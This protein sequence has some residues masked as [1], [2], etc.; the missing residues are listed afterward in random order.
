MEIKKKPRARL[1]NYSHLFLLIGLVLT[2]FLT[3]VAFE[4]KSYPRKTS[5]FN[6]VQMS[7]DI[8]E[9]MVITHRKEPTVIPLPPPPTPQMTEIIKVVDDIEDIPE[10][11]IHS[12][13]TDEN[14]AVVVSER[15]QIIEE[16]EEEEEIIQDVPFAI[17]EDIP[18]FPGCENGSKDEKKACFSKKIRKHINKKFDTQLGNELGLTPGKKK[19]YVMFTI[20]ENGEITEVQS[21]APHPRL[22]SE[23][24]RVVKSLPKMTP[25]KQRGTPVRVKY[26]VPITFEVIL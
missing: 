19:I 13:E 14:E 3:Y 17:I 24:A 6:T 7:Q 20:D 22:Q 21:R 10:T 12:S 11:I 1:E 9:E 25:G 23:A 15:I 4:H 8:I 16:L 26:A 2:L 18:V 5:S